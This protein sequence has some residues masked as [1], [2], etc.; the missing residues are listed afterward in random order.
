[1]GALAGGRLRDLFLAEPEATSPSSCPG[2]PWGNRIDRIDADAAVEGDA[3][4]SPRS[5]ASSRS[6]TSR[7]VGASRAL[8]QFALV[9]LFEPSS[10][11]Y[12]CPLAMTDGAAQHARSR[13]ATRRSS[14]ARSPRLTSRDPARAWTSGQWMTERT[15]GSDVGASARRSRGRTATAVRLYGT[16]WF[17]SATTSQM[18][19][20]L[21]RPE[22]NPRRRPRP[23]ALLPRAARRRRRLRN[24]IQINRLKDKLGTRKVPTAELA[25]DGTP[26][27]PVGGL[28]DGVREHHAD[29]QRHAHVERGLRGCRHAPRPRARAGLRAAARRVRRAA[30]RRSPC[31]PTRSR[32]S[33]AEYEGAFHLAFRAVE[34]LGREEA[35]AADRGRGRARSALLTPIAKLTTGKQAVARGERGARGLRRRRLRRGHGPAAR[36]CATRRCSRSGRARRTCCRSTSLRA[37]AKADAIAARRR[38]STR[39]WARARDARLAPRAPAQAGVARARAWLAATGGAGEP[40][41][42][43]GARGARA[44]AR[45][46]ARDRP[47]RRARGVGARAGRPAPRPSRRAPLP[48]RPGFPG[49][50]G[51]PLR[52]GHA[53][54]RR[55]RNRRRTALESHHGRLAREDGTRGLFL[56]GSEE[57]ERDGLDGREKPGR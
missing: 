46:R 43:E 19:L 15:G 4:A 51:R 3:R 38:R 23:R 21:A 56:R 26:A 24:G 25:L 14:T 9:Y 6:P 8:V 33:Q 52:G 1:M 32:S 36:S 10:G 27:T 17:T 42:L 16:K 28:T 13:T 55:A 11:V 53:R 29:A 18:A 45:S 35:G 57:R 48:A 49:R 40:T 39:S 30:R 12:S 44:D 22:G 31:T 37:V 5:R 47:S 50:R 20:T 41:T 2:T 34:L 7:P 54:A